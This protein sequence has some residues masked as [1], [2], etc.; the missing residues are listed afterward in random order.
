M[1]EVQSALSRVGK[2]SREDHPTGSMSG[3][4]P[5]VCAVGADEPLLSAQRI[6]R[7]PCKPVQHCMAV[8]AVLKP[9][10]EMLLSSPGSDYLITS[11]FP[12][13]SPHPSHLLL[14]T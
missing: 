6:Q 3:R 5:P 13:F 10:A 7:I 4:A 11:L 12:R 2:W 1:H 14:F 8:M 9:T